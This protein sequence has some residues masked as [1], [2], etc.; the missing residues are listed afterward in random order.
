MGGGDEGKCPLKF[1]LTW[2]D[3]IT[4]HLHP[5]TYYTNTSSPK[6]RQ[7]RETLENC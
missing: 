6:R 5:N 4:Y 3:S 7:E 1:F 2:H